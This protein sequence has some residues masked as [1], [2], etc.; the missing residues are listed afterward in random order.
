MA[1]GSSRR[2]GINWDNILS[3]DVLGVYK[4]DPRCYRRAAEIIDCEASDIMMVASH[5]SDLRGAMAT[6]FRSAYVVPRL[7]DPGDDYRDTGFAAEFDVVARDFP[8]LA[9][10]LGSGWPKGT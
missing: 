1:V 7:E 8:D 3:C 5:P 6:G 9:E 2:N 4:P 10:K